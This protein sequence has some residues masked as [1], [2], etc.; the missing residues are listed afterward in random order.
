VNF[1]VSGIIETWKLRQEREV[2]SF[3]AVY[4]TPSRTYPRAR[5]FSFAPD[6]L[7]IEV[8]IVGNTNREQE[9]ALGMPL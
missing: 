8:Q 2:R 5:P 1:D 9:H 3:P 6:P 7:D 4:R